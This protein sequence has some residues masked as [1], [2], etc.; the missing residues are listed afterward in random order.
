LGVGVVVEKDPFSEA[1]EWRAHPQS[2]HPF[3][4]ARTPAHPT[5]AAAASF[6]VTPASAAARASTAKTATAT[7]AAAI[8][9]IATAAA[10]AQ[11]FRAV[12][13]SEVFQTL[14]EMKLPHARHHLKRNK[15]NTPRRFIKKKKNL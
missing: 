2:N 13:L 15:S 3:L 10:A 4:L 14:L 5:A 8:A 9:A 11:R 12:P 7:A 6:A 1:Q